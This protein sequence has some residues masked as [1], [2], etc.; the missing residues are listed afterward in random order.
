MSLPIGKAREGIPDCGRIIVRD[1]DAAQI[2]S[3]VL[4]FPP[5]LA[6]IGP[7]NPPI[8]GVADL[9]KMEVAEPSKVIHPFSEFNK[10]M[11]LLHRNAGGKRTRTISNPKR[12]PGFGEHCTS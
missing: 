11:D 3:D 5:D 6:F 4:E 1:P 9:L 12:G 10:H 8:F 2:P 7:A